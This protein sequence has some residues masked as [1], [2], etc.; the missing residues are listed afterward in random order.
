MCQ[1]NSDRAIHSCPNE[2][3]RQKELKANPRAKQ[4]LSDAGDKR[5]VS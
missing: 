2:T 5:C 1:N 3:M 4:E